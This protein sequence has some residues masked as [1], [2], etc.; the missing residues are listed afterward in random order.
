[1]KVYKAFNKAISSYQLK[2]NDDWFLAGKSLLEFVSF[3]INYNSAGYRKLLW[4]IFKNTL[5]EIIINS[6]NNYP[7]KLNGNSASVIL[8][9][10][11]S[12]IELRDNYVR[13]ILGGN[14]DTLFCKN[15]LIVSYGIKDKFSLILYATWLFM[16]FYFTK[17]DVKTDKIFSFV[18]R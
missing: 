1:M 12:Y 4:S 16:K 11:L 14:P 5:K 6:G 17:T 15:N 10:S 7:V 8:D 9:C 18:L 13:T 2:S 3:R